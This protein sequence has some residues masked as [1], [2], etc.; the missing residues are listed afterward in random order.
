M[1]F[2]T[3]EEAIAEL[4]QGKMIIV[5][6]DEDRENEGDILVCAEHATPQVI[7]FMVTHAK[8]LVCVPMTQ[9]KL[10]SLGLHPMVA[11][12]TD[13]KG[14]AFTVSV[15]H[16]DCATGISAFERSGTI[17]ALLDNNSQNRDFTQPG[18]IFPLAAKDRGVL[19]RAGHTEAAVDLARLAGCKPAGVICEVISK[20]GTMA[21]VPELIDFAT[22]HSLKIITI[23]ALIE[24]RKKEE[25]LV[26]KIASAELPTKFG[27]FQMVGYREIHT[28]KHHIALVKGQPRKDTPCLVRVHSECLTGDT[29]GSLRCDCGGQLAAALVQIEAFGTGVFLYMTQEGRGIGILNKIKAYGLQDQGM[30]TV[31]ANLALGFPDDLREYSTGAQILSDLGVG[32]M[33]LLTNNPLKISGLSKYDLEI[34]ERVHIQMKHSQNNEHYLKTKKKKMGHLLKF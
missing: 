16:K 32:K 29:F 28:G 19:Q 1:R 24:Y 31:E 3:I 30:D 9:G 20:D 4:K 26:E 6:D 12:N 5:V 7:N 11:K 15:D 18:H 33:R 23:E 34:V 17:Q 10:D 22:E 13:A 2:D 27:N 25:K 14:T 8:G 21:R